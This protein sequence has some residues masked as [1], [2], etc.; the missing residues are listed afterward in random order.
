MPLSLLLGGA[1]KKKETSIVTMGM[2]N[3]IDGS[4][5]KQQHLGMPLMKCNRPRVNTPK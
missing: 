2:Q 5:E 3:P 1:K 4:L